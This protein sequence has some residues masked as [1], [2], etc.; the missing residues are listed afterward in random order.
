M[1]LPG[2]VMACAG[3]SALWGA[4]TV[5]KS[6]LTR[7]SG[8]SPVGGQ[9]TLYFKQQSLCPVPLLI[10]PS[11]NGRFWCCPFFAVMTNAAMNICV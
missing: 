7:G 2:D 11:G 6:P 4:Q 9:H 8:G 1:S 10:C 5:A 3:V